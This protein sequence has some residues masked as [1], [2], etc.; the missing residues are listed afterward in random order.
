GHV[1]NAGGAT[2]TVLH[3]LLQF[4]FA[5]LAGICVLAAFLRRAHRG[6][7]FTAA[8]TAGSAAG[9]A[10]YD[11]F[12][13]LSVFSMGTGWALF[14]ATS[15]I[16]LAWRVKSGFVIFLALGSALCIYPTYHDERY[17]KEEHPGLTSD[18]LSELETQAKKGE[19]GFGAFLRS[20]IPFRLV[21]GLDLK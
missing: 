18:Q 2:V 3:N 11:V 19:S 4:G 13:A 8:V 20:N 5:G 21:R 12:W 17:G 15:Y 16:D 9:A 6:S 7:F 1:R 10:R 14:C